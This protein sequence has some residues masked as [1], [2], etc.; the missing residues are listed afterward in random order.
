MLR[1]FS[2]VILMALQVLFYLFHYLGIP[3]PASM[4]IMRIVSRDLTR[5]VYKIF[6]LQSENLEE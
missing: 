5:A 1:L 6:S 2:S 4:Q 3:T